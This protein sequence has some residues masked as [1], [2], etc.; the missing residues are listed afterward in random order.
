MSEC[1]KAIDR[2]KECR[3]TGI[4][5]CYSRI[6]ETVSLPSW[7]TKDTNVISLPYTAA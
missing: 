7:Y 5:P 6:V 2:L 4:W 3:G 1:R